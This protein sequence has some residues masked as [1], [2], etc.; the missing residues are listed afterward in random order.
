VS[1]LDYKPW[2]LVHRGHVRCH[3]VLLD[4][5]QGAEWNHLQAF[6]KPNCSVYALDPGERLV[7]Y[8]SETLVDCGAVD[9]AVLV[10]EGHLFSTLPLTK[11]A[12]ER[13]P[14]SGRGVV[15]GAG[16]LLRY[17]PFTDA[18]RTDGT[19]WFALQDF[20]FVVAEPLVSPLGLGSIIP[21]VVRDGREALEHG[22]GEPPQEAAIFESSNATGTATGKP[23]AAPRLTALLWRVIQ[24]SSRLLWRLLQ[25]WSSSSATATHRS[26]GRPAHEQRQRLSLTARFSSWLRQRVW[27]SQLGRLFGSAQARYLGRML[28][29]FA[30]GDLDEALRHAIP[31]SK[32]VAATSASPRL[33]PGGRRQRLELGAPRERRGSLALEPDLFAHLRA[34]Y[35]AA[36]QQLVNRGQIADAAFVLS[37]LLQDDA[38]AVAFLESHGLL[39]QAAKLA[40]LRNLSPGLVVRQWFLAGNSERAIAIA[41]RDCAFEDA[42]VRL[43]GIGAAQLALRLAW[44][45]FLATSGNYAGAA[46]VLRAEQDGRHVA[47]VWLDR[48]IEVGGVG[49]AEALGMRIHWY[50]SE[51]ER[52][53]ELASGV[54]DDDGPSAPAARV[55]L[56][57]ELVRQTGDD[58]R[59]ILRPLVRALTRDLH[60]S[61]ALL[62]RDELRRLASISGDGA[63]QADLPV[64]SLELPPVD[65]PVPK[66][67]VVKE[68]DRGTIR[69]FDTCLL[70]RRRFL[71]ANGEAGCS[72]VTAE[73]RTIRH[74]DVPAERIVRSC[75]GDRFLTLAQRD[76]DVLVSRVDLLANAASVW[77]ELKLTAF[78]SSFDGSSWYVALDNRVH[79]LDATSEHPKSLWTSGEASARVGSVHWTA[80][81]MAFT[82]T[83]GEIWLHDLQPHRLT[84]REFI[85]GTP[86][87][88]PKGV[89]AVLRAIP[90]EGTKIV[91]LCDPQGASRIPFGAPDHVAPRIAHYDGNWVIVPVDVPIEVPRLIDVNLVN[92]EA[93]RTAARLRP[94]SARTTSKKN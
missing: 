3:G 10:K 27:R 12:V 18:Q 49:G 51:F 17:R 39:L 34:T 82:T 69:I 13:L 93:F 5:V 67:I 44:A 64:V 24:R 61:P 26:L 85:Q 35:E 37:E 41:R 46:R 36:F 25:R 77:C 2:Q 55:A 91:S 56:A 48:A 20:E 88:G 87:I 28:D 90:G 40:E 79:A 84:R 4:R 16:G 22:I 21:V 50:G 78:A 65:S 52:H 63:L 86:V 74:Y 58:E 33:L 6:W 15:D 14:T 75:H 89:A 80:Q 59:T 62:A 31:T 19:H 29:M 73:G 83:E 66:R 81:R 72:V 54:L 1:R 30:R 11:K 70:S 38:R 9:A 45:D 47:K 71:V 94:S 42:V 7:L 57:R 53:R 76:D 68:T 23:G 43:K 32:V 8:Q 92:L 60:E